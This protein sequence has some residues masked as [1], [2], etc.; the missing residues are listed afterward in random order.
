MRIF[1]FFRDFETKAKEDI[2]KVKNELD[3]EEKDT[4]KIEKY[5]NVLLKHSKNL[6]AEDIIEYLEAIKH[7]FDIEEK[8]QN[9]ILKNGEKLSDKSGENLSK[10]FNETELSELKGQKKNLKKVKKKLHKTIDS[11][12][13][14]YENLKKDLGHEKAESKIL[15][16]G[17]DKI[18]NAIDQLKKD[19]KLLYNIDSESKEM[20]DNLKK[21]EKKIDDVRKIKHE[22]AKKSKGV[23][24]SDGEKLFPAGTLYESLD[25]K[26][27]V[28]QIGKY[29]HGI[30]LLE[31]KN[32]VDNW[33]DKNG[34][35]VMKKDGEY[36]TKNPYS[37]WFSGV[38]M[39]ILQNDEL[40][41]AIESFLVDGI[42]TRSEKNKSEK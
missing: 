36:F 13:E 18:R 23:V 17:R 10:L 2:E 22:H 4:E 39:G 11:L 29:R 40:N 42:T 25:G 12:R 8:E 38:E 27:F 5:I 37:V 9:T 33:E 6:K 20:I 28:Y 19:Y 32:E 14:K 15:F 34:K 16:E 1:D 31:N 30:S 7:L 35:I 24:S 21:E 3:K 26:R 41:E